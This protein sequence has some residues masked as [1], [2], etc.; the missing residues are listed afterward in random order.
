MKTNWLN[1]SKFYPI[2]IAIFGLFM[3]FY[4]TYLVID[5]INLENIYTQCCGGSPCSDTYYTADDNKCHYSLCERDIFMI[6]KSLCVYEGAN[7]T[8][9][10]SGLAVL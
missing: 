4:V 10:V 9:N 6:D 5:T 1:K 7:I 8:F 2:F 3:V